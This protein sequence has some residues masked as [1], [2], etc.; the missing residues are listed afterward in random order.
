[1]GE[2]TQ[3]KNVQI[4]NRPVDQPLIEGEVVND[5]IRSNR[6][7]LFL[8]R[9][10]TVP[11]AVGIF[12]LITAVYAF[13]HL[14]LTQPWLAIIPVALLVMGIYAWK[15]ELNMMEEE[16]PEERAQLTVKN[17]WEGLRT[18]HV[19]F[20]IIY[21]PLCLVFLLEVIWEYRSIFIN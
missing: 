9:K 11:S 13:I 17:L 5:G 21:L 12:I 19:W 14:C 2:S 8:Q 10:A 1:V 3:F 18:W 4:G 6:Y 16:D 20:L 7:V 15:Y